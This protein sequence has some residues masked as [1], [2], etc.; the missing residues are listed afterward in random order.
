MIT[1]R[2]K[3]AAT[4]IKVWHIVMLIFLLA[5]IGAAPPLAE[6]EI[7]RFINYQGKL[8][9]ANDDPVTGDV[10]ITV[11]IYDVETG[12]TALWTET[13]VTTVT[14]GVFSILLGNTEVLDNLDFNVPYWYSVEVESDGEMT[15]RQ[16]LTSVAYAIN[17]DKLDGY[18]AADFLASAPDGALSLTGGANQ[19]VELNP[20]GTGDVVIAIDAT[21]GDFK[22][23]DG[24]TNFLIV[25]SATGNVSIAKDLT[26][27]GTIY[28][29]L[30]STGGD[31]TFSNIIVTGGS[32]LRGSV[33][34]SGG[35]VTIA[36]A[37]TQTGATNQVTF[38][39]NIDAGNGLDVTGAL[40]VDG[41]A[42]LN[43]SLDM[44]SNI[45][46]DYSGDSAA[47][48]VTQASTGAAAQFT[49]GRVLVGDD[50]TNA[51]ALS[52][53]ELYVQ[54]DMEIDGTIYG[55]I[56]SEGT[57]TLGDT[58]LATLTVTGTSDLKGNIA[59][60]AGVLTIADNLAVSNTDSSVTG[61]KTAAVIQP[62]YQD[63]GIASATKAIGLNIN[64][65]IN[66][67][68]ASRT[69]SYTALKIAAA[70][71]SVPTGTNYL[72]DAYAGATGT[73]QK[74]YV[75]NSGNAKIF[76]TLDMNGQRIL[77]VTPTDVNSEFTEVA[78]KGYVDSII[79]AAGGG[80]TDA[81][82]GVYLISASDNIGVGTSETATYKMNVTGSTNTTT[83]FIDGTQITASAAEL[84]KL[85][86]AGAGVTAG[87]LST[88]TAGAVSNADTLHTHAIGTLTG[89][90]VSSIEGVSNDGGNIDLVAGSNITIAADDTANT[91]T[92]ASQASGDEVSTTNTTFTLDS[93]NPGSGVAN[94][95][96]IVI[97]GGT[98][99]DISVKFNSAT[100]N[101]DV[102]GVTGGLNIPSGA[103]YKIDGAQIASTDLSDSANLAKLEEASVI[104]GDWV[105]TTH[106]WAD[107]EVADTI[108]ASNYL[109]L[110]GGAM[111]GGI[112]TSG[113]NLDM[114]PAAGY[115]V[116]SS[117]TRSAGTG[118]ETAYDLAATIDKATSGNYTGVKLNVTETSA[119]GAANKL[120]DLQ[121]EEAS[122]FAVD[123]A[124]LI[125]TASADSASI[126][127]NSVTADDLNVNVV[128]SLDGVLNDGGNIDLVEGTNITI[129]PNDGA[130]TI[131]I[132]AT[133]TVLSQEAVG[134]YVG[135]MVSGNIE[136]HIDVTYDDAVNKLNFDVTSVPTHSHIAGDLPVAGAD[137]AGIIPTT[138]LTNSMVAAA[139]GIQTSKLAAGADI[140]DAITKKHTQGTDT[141]LG[142]MAQDIEMGGN[143]ITGLGD[144]AVGTNAATKTYVDNAIAGLHWK[145]P[146]IAIQ[147]T[148]PVDPASGDRYVVSP[149]GAGAWADE[150]NNIA[151]YN[152]GTWDFTPPLQS[153]AVFNKT[154]N[155]GYVYNGTSWVAFSG[156]SAYT[157]GTGLTN[158]GTTVS[159]DTTVIANLTGEQTLTNKTISG[160][161]NTLQNISDTSLSTITTAG[162]VS[163]SAV[164]LAS[165]GGLENS[166]GLKVDY[167]NATI[168]IID[169][170]LAVK[171]ESIGSG[172]ITDS[173]VTSAKILDGTIASADISNSAGILDSQ[174]ATSP[175]T[176]FYENLA[177]Y[178]E[179]GLTPATSV[180]L[181]SDISAGTAYVRGARVNK[182]GAT[183]NTYA[184]N[185]DTYVDINS[186]GVFQ[187]TA[188]NNGAVEP[189][190]AADSIRLAKVVTDAD[191]ITEVDTSVKNSFPVTANEIAPGAVT[192]TGIEDG[193]IGTE[194]LA[195]SAVTSIKIADGT[196]V[197]E[198]IS[199]TAAIDQSKVDLAITNDEVAAAAGIEWSKIDKTGSSPV[200]VGAAANSHTH[201]TTDL[202]GV[203]VTAPQ[204]SQ[205]IQPDA[206]VI[207]LT[208][209]GK[210]SATSNVLSIYDAA[211]APAEKI[212]VDNSGRMHIAEA[213]TGAAQASSATLYF[214]RN[215]TDNWETMGYDPALGTKGKFT[216]S[217]PLQ[218][219]ASS[220]TGITFVEKDAAG[221]IIKSQGLTYDPDLDEFS[222]TGGTL[223]QAFQNLIKNPSF[224]TST[225]MGWMGLMNNYGYAISPSVFKFGTKSVILNDSD[226]AGNRGIKSMVSAL[227]PDWKRLMGKTVTLSF[228]AKA[229][230]AVTTSI[231]FDSL[232]TETDMDTDNEIVPEQVNDIALTSTW[233]NF[234]FSYDVP[235]SV[236]R[237][238]VILYG[239][240]Y[241]TSGNN[242]YTQNI[243]F[244]GIT[245]VE[246]N[247]ALDYG[248][249]PI[250]DTGNQVVYGSMAIG[251][252]YDPNSSTNYY[253][254]PRLI[255]GQPDSY[256]G[257]GYGGWTGGSGEIRF[258]KWGANNAG[259]FMFNRGVWLRDD[260][261]STYGATLRIGDISEP[262][263]ANAKGDVY[264]RGRLELGGIPSGGSPSA[265]LV[266]G[267]VIS[268][269]AATQ[270]TFATAANDAYIR[271][272]IEADGGFYGDGSNLTNVN[273]A[274]QLNP[275]GGIVDSSGLKV[276]VDD[277]TIGITSNQLAL[278][279]S[280]ADGS[281]YDTRFVNAAGDTITGSIGFDYSAQGSAATLT[282]AAT[283]ATGQNIT[284]YDMD[285][286]RQI[287]EPASG[288]ASWSG[289]VARIQ[290]LANI[291]GVGALT[292][293][294]AV[295]ELNQAS[296]GNT[297]VLKGDGAP[298]MT[299]AKTGDITLGA[300]ADTITTAA[301]NNLNIKLGDAAGT[302]KLSVQTS[303]GAESFA[304]LSDG[305]V[306]IAG[307]YT[308]VVG[309]G[310]TLQPN[311]DIYFD[312]NMYQ[313]GDTY[314]VDTV[315]FTGNY[316]V[317]MISKFG[318]GAD[319]TDANYLQIDQEGVVTKSGA[320]NNGAV[321]V[322]D[323]FTQTGSA[324]QVTF[325]GNIDAQNSVDVTGN[326]TLTGTVDGVDI[327]SDSWVTS[328]KIADG[329][330]ATAD[331]AAAAVSEANIATGAVARSKVME[332]RPYATTPAPD[333]KVNVAAGI[334]SV[335]NNS[336][337][338]FAGSASPAFNPVTAN[339]RIDIL[340]IDSSGELVIIPGS[341]AAAPAAPAYPTDK[342]VVA[343]VTIT[344]TAVQG[345]QI[346][347]SD[348]KDVRPFLNLSA[349]SGDSS[350][351]STDA[352][353]FTIGRNTDETA[354]DVTLALGSADG[355]Q[356][357]ITYT[358]A[359]TKDFVF[360]D[361]VSIGAN[362]LKFTDTSLTGAKVSG[363]DSHLTDISNPHSVTAAQIGGT[364]IVNE[365]NAIATTGVIDLS[366][367]APELL[368][369]VEGDARYLTPVKAV[370]TPEYQNGIVYG[371]G[372]NNSGTIAVK[373][374]SDSNRRNYYEWSSRNATLQDYM[375]TVRY[376]LPA[377]FAG[378]AMANAIK[379]AY[380]TGTGNS[381]DNKT[382]VNIYK[383]GTADNIFSSLTNVSDS[384]AEI[385]IDDSSLG[386]WSAGDILI[387]EIKVYSKNSNFTRT[388][389]ITLNYTR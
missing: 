361:D 246:G 48:G 147:T 316:D 46:L 100:D 294:A 14:K 286:S 321:T 329:T 158:A 137:T 334:I 281:T 285:I 284:E 126:V 367:L 371:D 38:A 143:Q 236:V 385:T 317:G 201:S 66:Y 203:V 222:F 125:T 226:S 267:Q 157:W 166:S 210:A 276:N 88:L 120:L 216:F 261:T 280:Y 354:A 339:S 358:G 29:K 325:Q 215:A 310:I 375:I 340:A 373:N 241:S 81:G 64:P 220:P 184:A 1:T 331:I 217:A 372:S 32:D 171:S 118:D 370:I 193:S 86:G 359:T 131:T 315:R 194:K 389:D 135:G 176:R 182:A 109:P 268:G 56:S 324:N 101:L 26:V 178:V 290:N 54:G 9:D 207:P 228:W 308:G 55:N 172:Q 169:D 185:K 21:S 7:P 61:T 85:A 304:V 257:A 218:V 232:G 212:Y 330:I 58:T 51:Y 17:A 18:D 382:D 230:S 149:A 28:G 342:L 161:A 381:V 245:L 97:N 140:N 256:F 238:N 159:V 309:G 380:V 252:N 34:N 227:D 128:S 362:A 296:S 154:D 305:T 360:N 37:L 388:G 189:I 259:T 292:D 363:Y 73:D 378:W 129:T 277:T 53:G 197:N 163:G 16:R 355:G 124:G 343:E 231:G 63:G 319:G 357:T 258:M 108:T 303:G 22:I 221:T 115:G 148:P 253:E 33:S 78:T 107:A 122:K 138:G 134:D 49:G 202:T 247:L 242:V 153:Y 90:V 8:T 164:Q 13:H 87:N 251:A 287:T 302:N 311:G 350:I 344:E 156:A 180:S 68:A 332:L 71:T 177:E 91:I 195:N 40:T 270:P 379:L 183:S 322:A 146:V 374:T 155:A 69:G 213:T 264:A 168:G 45:N 278:K 298:V 79:P 39:G 47:L 291:A 376:E 191:N 52:A 209:K 102:A 273:T 77:N 282:K 57:T 167:D 318:V 15:P 266:V 2:T 295:L 337:I 136:T 75:D 111:T 190:V 387:I 254:S 60:S 314:A 20:T 43:N 174:L 346:A 237:L 364:N 205:I 365:I 96:G 336:R 123:N 12:G 3:R 269:A 250:F 142:I 345:V 235:A 204:S 165:A 352:V 301:A 229:D 366:R 333:N 198:D 62:A 196:I 300:G 6:A 233:Q 293:N 65:T 338:D 208:V 383:A 150:D 234:K 320:G 41:A 133:D 272:K 31:S 274:I 283:A 95:A 50:T 289:A 206:D 92:F 356:K 225:P 74:F 224:E 104:T 110:A 306:K 279:S 299:F 67:T 307:G 173:A 341:Q 199:V 99:T 117:V 181:T 5:F 23:T 327:S 262:A 82:T 103:Y 348:I 312:G 384:W 10:S 326:I 313:K 76:G 70:E 98:G 84:N 271:G 288:T 243:Y 139:A 132:A 24:T 119:P 144:P 192:S 127:D 141:A 349:G 263:Y 179:S 30:A 80:W 297:L 187:Y 27:S 25:D 335:S 145:D 121:V 59:N 42:T 275:E 265:T 94:G 4:G 113:A 160:A 369:Q 114:S 106:P 260:Y 214:G 35:A 152:D 211:A 351:S 323:A 170:K 249:T 151:V 200:D 83:L 377:D 44:N 353:K 162:K 89:N 239:A 175:A 130:N 112:T 328:Q 347:D 93:D 105:N 386:S 19:N 116:T 186:S 223:K 36:D 244:D 11:R 188:V 219:E 72:I 248:P 255:F 240:Q 368:T